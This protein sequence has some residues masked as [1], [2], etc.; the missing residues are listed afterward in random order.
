MECRIG[1]VSEIRHRQL[2]RKPGDL[3]WRLCHL[4]QTENLGFDIGHN[5]ELL[6]VI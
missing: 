3:S 6:Q 2:E 4:H 5:V 1:T